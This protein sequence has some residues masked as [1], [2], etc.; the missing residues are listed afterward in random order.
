MARRKNNDKQ[1]F[2]PVRRVCK[3]RK[4]NVSDEDGTPPKRKILQS[5]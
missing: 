1:E 3:M 4:E 5:Q 2:S